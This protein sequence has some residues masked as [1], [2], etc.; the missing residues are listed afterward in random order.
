MR[1]SITLLGT[2]GPRPDAARG[3]TALLIEAGEDV[4]LIDAGRGVVRQVAALGV[5]LDRI[6]PCW[7]PTTTTTT[8][9]SYTM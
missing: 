1:P 9:V 6:D 5:A 4:I 2:G 7:S 3:A 8:S